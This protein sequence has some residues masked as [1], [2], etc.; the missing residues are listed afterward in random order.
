MSNNI[1]L[2]ALP[3]SRLDTS[4]L[5]EWLI[6]NLA[7]LQSAQF[8]VAACE[9]KVKKQQQ[10]AAAAAAVKAVQLRMAGIQDQE[11]ADSKD[12]ADDDSVVGMTVAFSPTALGNPSQLVAAAAAAAK[13]ADKEVDSAGTQSDTPSS[14]LQGKSQGR[15]PALESRRSSPADNFP[16]PD[17]KSPATEDWPFAAEAKPAASGD[18][19]FASEGIFSAAAGKDISPPPPQ[20]GP[21]DIRNGAACVIPI[22]APEASA[23]TDSTHAQRNFHSLNPFPLRH[24]PEVPYRGRTAGPKSLLQHL[25]Q[26]GTAPKG[27]VCHEMV[28]RQLQVMSACFDQL[29]NEVSSNSCSTWSSTILYCQQALPWGSNVC[30]QLGMASALRQSSIGKSQRKPACKQSFRIEIAKQQQHLVE[31]LIL[32]NL[33]YE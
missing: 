4:L 21:E 25:M 3:G 9:A 12:K 31:C 33:S 15:P 30:T 29:C 14:Q 16:G 19:P 5:K 13:A 18:Q 10:A 7:V 2:Q 17:C 32:C 26:P 28:L 24:D 8:R 23:V 11:D 6:Q 1:L 20:S 27:S 22:A